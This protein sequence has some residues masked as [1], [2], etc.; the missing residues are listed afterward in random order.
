MDFFAEEETAFGNVVAG[1]LPAVLALLD[2]SFLLSDDDDGEEERGVVSRSVRTKYE[3]SDCARSLNRDFLGPTPKFKFSDVFRISLDRFWAIFHDIRESNN[4]FFFNQRGSGAVPEARILLPLYCLAY[5][6]PP[7]AVAHNYQMSPIQ[8]RMCCIQFDKAMT[9]LYVNEYMRQPTADDLQ[10]ITA[11]HEEVHGVPGM[12][13]SLDCMHH[14][15]KNCPTAWKGSFQG[16]EGK[17]TLVLEGV[18]DY[19]L[20]FWHGFYGCAGSFNDLNV[21][22]LSNLMTMFV[23]GSFSA[24]EESAGVVPYNITGEEFA[25]LFLLVDGIYPKY[26]RFVKGIK[27]PVTRQECSYTGWQEAARKDIERAFGVLQ[28]RWKFMRN[29]IELMTM[30]IITERVKTCLILHNMCVSDRVMGGDVR[31]LY[32]PINGAPRPPD[33]EWEDSSTDDDTEEEE[34][35]DDTDTEEDDDDNNNN[36]NNNNDTRKRGREDVSCNDSVGELGIGIDMVNR[37]WSDVLTDPNEHARLHTALKNK[38]NW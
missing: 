17:P 37:R 36:N 16:K 20:W 10:S 23:D 1:A 13:G 4:T 28:G 11:L 19:N 25:A 6:L 30:D 24:I 26:S 2:V 18:C 29:P 22:R 33:N 32:N 21:L 5:G 38:F 31:A 27:D 34:E 8:G 7:R 14:G 35:G 9:E 15:W 3:H 12:Y